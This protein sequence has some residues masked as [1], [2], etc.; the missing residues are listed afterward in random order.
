MSSG[1]TIL[2]GKTRV[3]VTVEGCHGCGTA[4]TSGWTGAEMVRIVIGSH[5]VDVRLPLCTECA[6]ASAPLNQER[7]PLDAG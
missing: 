7:L 1:P 4:F 3:R 5:R 6:A 2:M